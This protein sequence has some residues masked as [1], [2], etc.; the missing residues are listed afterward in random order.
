MTTSTIDR[1]TLSATVTFIQTTLDCGEFPTYDK[2]ARIAAQFGVGMA[3]KGDHNHRIS[4]WSLA[5]TIQIRLHAKKSNPTQ[6][7]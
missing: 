3:G 5:E 6:G 4:I 1:T 7:K 2:A